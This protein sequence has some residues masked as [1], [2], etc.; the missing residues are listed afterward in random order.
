MATDSEPPPTSN[1]ASATSASA[2]SA[3]ESWGESVQNVRDEDEG[4]R[5]KVTFF[6]YKNAQRSNAE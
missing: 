3:G 1:S 2:A 5:G 4:R 6:F